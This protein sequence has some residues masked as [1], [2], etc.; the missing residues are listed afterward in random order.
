[1]KDAGEVDE[2]SVAVDEQRLDAR[3]ASA[4]RL[5]TVR[6]TGL[7]DSEAEEAFDALTRLAS[8]L[9]RAPV[10]F[11]SLV[12]E[13]R[14]F[15]KSQHGLPEALA[16][17]RQLEGRTFCHHALSTREPLAI[18]DT[19]ADPVWRSVPTVASLGVRAYLGVPIWIGGEPIGSLC[20]ADV[21]PRAWTALEIETL[22]QLARSA[23]REIELRAA[24]GVAHREAEQ[25]RA[26]AR[27]REELLA[28][29]AHDLRSP[30]QTIGLGAA[31]LNRSPDAAVQD[32]ARR[33][34]SAVDSMERLVDDLFAPH[35]AGGG[36]AQR[37]AQM[38]VRALIDD[39]ADAM[40]PV[41]SRAGIS[42]SVGAVA[43]AVL[44]VDHAQM[45]RAIC[46]VIGN[47]IKYCP[48]G[49]SVRL[50]ATAGADGT[51]I[52]IVDDG[53]GMSGAHL[54]EA[55]VRGWQGPDGRTRRDGAGLGLFIVQSL[56]EQNGGRV[57]I[58]SVPGSGVVVTIVFPAPGPGF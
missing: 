25:A 52:S 4:S 42:L 34:A 6:A 49:S 30:L 28:V 15:Y 32:H 55:F 10:S 13:R 24:L 44:F 19:H 21:Q 57:D 23:E 5:A 3:R 2:R 41:A 47:S 53:P 38:P 50:G 35:A 58:A 16:A 54:A 8:V 11:L 39:A 31:L 37:R 40:G 48:A 1:M 22:A 29:V 9:V 17:A 33:I 12:D 56:A 51:A 14:D 43:E 7:L 45:L 20:V 36:A 46:N 18:A 26:N 27:L